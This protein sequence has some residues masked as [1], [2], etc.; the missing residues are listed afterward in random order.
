MTSLMLFTRDLRVDDNP[1]LYAAAETGHFHC[2]FVKDDRVRSSPIASERRNNFLEQC[3][4]DLSHSLTQR[5]SELEI[6]TGDWLDEVTSRAADLG[7]Q[8]IHM[9][10]LIHI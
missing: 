6:L 7:A 1:A 10:S 2:L 9:L 5:G 8:S 3:L 4:K